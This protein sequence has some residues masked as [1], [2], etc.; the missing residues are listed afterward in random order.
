MAWRYSGRQDRKPAQNAE[1]TVQRAEPSAETAGPERAA[2]NDNKAH[3]KYHPVHAERQTEMLQRTHA[4]VDM[5]ARAHK[6]NAVQALGP[7][8]DASS[9]ASLARRTKP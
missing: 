3:G 1:R 6:K 7:Q 2:R 9:L 5:A 8:L 4:R